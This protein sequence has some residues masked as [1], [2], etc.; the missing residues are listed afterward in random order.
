M[1]FH[2]TVENKTQ[3]SEKIFQFTLKPEQAICQSIEPGSHIDVFLKNGEQ[4]QYS[5]FDCDG[6][7][8]KIAVQR[9]TE[10][11]GGSIEIC[12]TIHQGDR[13]E[14]SEPRNLFKLDLNY[15]KYILLG[16]GIGITPII[17]MASELQKKSLPFELHYCV[18]DEETAAFS[19]DLI[20]R[21]F[22]LTKIHYDNGA[23]EQKLHLSEYFKSREP[24]SIIYMCGPEGFMNAVETA[25]EHWPKGSVVKENFS[26]PSSNNDAEKEAFTVRVRS[27]DQ[28]IRVEANESIIEALRK[29]GITVNTSCSEGVCGS[30]I[31]DI[32]SGKPVHNDACLTDE[33]RESGELIVPCVS[34][35]AAEEE[36]VLDI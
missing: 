33:E 21:N 8:L 1:T 3:L 15:D 31:V 30:C 2:A 36:L 18:R 19:K 22:P 7:S 17:S 5:V 16:G 4:R 6:D 32:V 9:E 34:R 28:I 11:R 14:I 29:N 20:D 26:A 25:T 35:A 23:E 10:G 13:I 24:S 12:D 27:T